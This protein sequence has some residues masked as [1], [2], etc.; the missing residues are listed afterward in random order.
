M[1]HNLVV[2]IKSTTSSSDIGVKESC[3]AS[4][5][6]ATSPIVAS[7]FLVLAGES[8]SRAWAGQVLYIRSKSNL[9]YLKA[10]RVAMP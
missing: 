5:R 7:W 3:L 4:G 9:Q 6:Q 2:N 8:Q 10:W 1:H